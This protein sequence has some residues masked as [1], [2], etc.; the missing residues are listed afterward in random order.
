MWAIAEVLL[1]ALTLVTG[2]G[3]SGP[4]AVD[5]VAADDG[6]RLLVMN[7]GPG[8]ARA[9][10]IVLPDRPGAVAPPD[11]AEIRVLR[12][13]KWAW[14]PVDGEPVTAGSTVNASWEHDGVR[15]DAAFTLSG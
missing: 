5:V 10:R 9:V 11:G 12:P 6:R 8:T 7:H 3:R 2:S 1:E 14:L 4:A 13:G 15:A